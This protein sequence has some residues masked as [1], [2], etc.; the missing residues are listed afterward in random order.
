VTEF[1]QGSLGESAALATSVLWTFTAVFFT[2][3]SLRIG[4][5]TVNRIRLLVAVV[6]LSVLHAVVLGSFFPTDATGRQWLWLGLSGLVGLTVGDTLLFQSLVDLGTQRAML[7]MASWPILAA[8]MAF[9]F[10]GEHL[11]AHELAGVAVTIGSIAWVVSGGRREA[12]G[13]PGAGQHPGRGTA[14]ALGGALCQAIGVLMAKEGLAGG[15]APLSGTL[16]RMAAAAAGL[17]LVSLVR[18]DAGDAFRRLASDRRGALFTLCGAITGPTLGVWLSLV[19]VA[20]G[21]VGVVAALMSLPPV[22]LIPIGRFVF[23][24]HITVR[25]VLGTLGA[26]AGVWLLLA[27]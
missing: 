6:F 11:S 7:V 4:A 19:A 8:L 2:L 12:G 25:A 15:C 24:D 26:L 17:W 1:L 27:P 21:K 14:L 16:I 10:L 22:L 9:A 5:Y 3:A 20:Y 23:H 18:R 13:T